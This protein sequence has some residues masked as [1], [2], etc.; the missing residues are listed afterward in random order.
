MAF[1]H[2]RALGRIGAFGITE[3]GH[4][5]ALDDAAA[6]DAHAASA[7]LVA[8]TAVAAFIAPTITPGKSAPRRPC[9]RGDM[10]RLAVDRTARAAGAT[11]SLRTKIRRIG[12]AP[13]GSAAAAENAS[14][15]EPRGLGCDS[16]SVTSHVCTSRLVTAQ[17]RHY[18]RQSDDVK[19]H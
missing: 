5:G 2:P 10:L 8:K 15:R 17:S 1:Q 19:A 13:F 12:I 6:G 16:Y 9:R 4:A 7:T 18:A 3:F 14:A 11:R